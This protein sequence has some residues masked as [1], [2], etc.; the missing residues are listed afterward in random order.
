MDTQEVVLFGRTESA[1]SHLSFKGKSLE[2]G[3]LINRISSQ[4]SSFSFDRIASDQSLGG[5]D[6]EET[7][8]NGQ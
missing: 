1:R 3:A 4:A 6:E 2:T 7:A 8:L 5:I